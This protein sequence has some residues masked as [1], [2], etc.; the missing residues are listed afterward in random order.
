MKFFISRQ[1]TET[2]LVIAVTG[3]FWAQSVTLLMF[4]WDWPQ[5][6]L[7]GVFFGVVT[8]GSFYY[9]LL[10]IPDGITHGWLE[11]NL[12]DYTENMGKVLR[13]TSLVQ[14]VSFTLMVGM[15]W[16]ETSLYPPAFLALVSGFVAFA[17]SGFAGIASN[18]LWRFVWKP[19]QKRRMRWKPTPH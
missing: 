10:Y 17:A 18:L 12:W 15:F 9:L 8:L 4:L 14:V 3:V 1:G 7:A 13:Y 16:K 6:A 19:Q 11:G 2:L 5:R